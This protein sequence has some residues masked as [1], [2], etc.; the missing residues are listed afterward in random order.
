MYSISLVTYFSPCFLLLLL[1]HLVKGIVFF[2]MMNETSS[3]R[4][5]FIL[6]LVED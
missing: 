5:R 3:F 2:G 6:F 1:T 4:S